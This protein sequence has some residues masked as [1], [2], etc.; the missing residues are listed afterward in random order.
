MPQT[1][2]RACP[3]SSGSNRSLRPVI[4]L[5]MRSATSGDPE[6]RCAREPVAHQR[7]R[8]RGEERGELGPVV[9]PGQ[10]EAERHVERLALAARARLEAL[11]ERGEVAAGLRIGRERRVEEAGTGF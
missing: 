8:Y 5:W 4:E 11:G 6:L 1:Y 7:L 10:S 3:R 2:I 9:P